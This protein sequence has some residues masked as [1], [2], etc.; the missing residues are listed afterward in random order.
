VPGRGGES[1]LL[2]PAAHPHGSLT[3]AETPLSDAENPFREPGPLQS[4]ENKAISQRKAIQHYYGEI[5]IAAVAAAVRHQG[6]FKNA[7]YAPVAIEWYDR[8]GSAV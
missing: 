6:D 3:P 5:G 8:R 7:A 2:Q 1:S 4:S